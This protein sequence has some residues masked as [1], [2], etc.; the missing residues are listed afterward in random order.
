MQQA[1]NILSNPSQEFLP[2]LP[3][4]EKIK[5][6]ENVFLGIFILQRFPS[7]QRALLDKN[8]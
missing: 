4:T 6:E 7:F 2:P 3:K 1:N 8:P 5:K